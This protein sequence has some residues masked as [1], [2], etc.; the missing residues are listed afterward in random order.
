M[1]NVK[2]SSKH[3][4]TIGKEAFEAAGFHAGDI[5]TVRAT[6]PGRVEVVSMHSVLEKYAGILD[7]ADEMRLTIEELRNEWD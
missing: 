4:I 3:Q 6:G 1:Y 2:N 7:G 5:V